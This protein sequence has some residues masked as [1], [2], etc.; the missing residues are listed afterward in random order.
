M[1]SNFLEVL[2]GPS[3][4]ATDDSAA[5]EQVKIPNCASCEEDTGLDRKTSECIDEAGIFVTSSMVLTALTT[6]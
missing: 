2:Q 6:N 5:T 3:V 4:N 1:F